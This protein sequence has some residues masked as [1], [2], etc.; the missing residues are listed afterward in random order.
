MH[1]MK[2]K[3][4][5]IITLIIHFYLY[6]FI[7]CSIQRMKKI[8]DDGDYFI[9]LDSGIYLYNFEKSTQINITIFNESIFDTND[10]YNHIIISKNQD[11][12]SNEIK[13]GALINHHLYIYTYDDSNNKLEYLLI[14]QLKDSRHLTHSFQVKI[15]NASI[16]IVYLV[17]SEYSVRP[18]K[19]QSLSFQ[20]YLDIKPNEP[21]IDIYFEEKYL[22]NSYLF[23]QIDE[24]DSLIKCVYEDRYCRLYFLNLK[25]IGDSDNSQKIKIYEPFYCQL[26]QYRFSNITYSS[27]L[28]TIFVCANR[29]NEIKCYYSN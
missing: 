20:N 19:I 2:I 13:I 23:C 9:I 15:N 28:E 27:N 16:I 17:A 25:K 21:N 11:D 1:S 3:Y 7:S 6:T 10:A 12:I 22:Y 26:F 14:E 4:G 5:H 8:S 29:F 18:D 24:Y